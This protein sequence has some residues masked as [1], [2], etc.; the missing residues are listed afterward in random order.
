ME[1]FD[2]AGSNPGIVVTVRRKNENPGVV[3]RAGS[4]S[5]TFFTP[6]G[7]EIHLS[8]VE[9]RSGEWDCAR[10]DWTDHKKHDS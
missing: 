7:A 5:D 4:G 6:G 9:R 8:S 1:V 3:Y 10:E 2:F